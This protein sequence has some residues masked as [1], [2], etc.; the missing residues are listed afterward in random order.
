MAITNTDW[1]ATA[2]PF[3]Y[4]TAHGF[5]SSTSEWTFFRDWLVDSSGFLGAIIDDP[6]IQE[7]YWERDNDKTKTIPVSAI[8]TKSTDPLLLGVN[9]DGMEVGDID[10]SHGGTGYGKFE[11]DDY[12]KEDPKDAFI[13]FKGRTDGTVGG[14]VYSLYAYTAYAWVA[15]DPAQVIFS[16]I[17][18][19]MNTP[20]LATD[21]LDKASFQAA[22]DYYD[23]NPLPLS[24]WREVGLTL[25]QQ[26]KKI[27][28][29]TPDYLAIRPSEADGKIKLHLLPRQVGLVKR[30]TAVD[31][32]GASV[33]SYQVTP[34]DRH[35]L[36]RITATF[37][38][39]FMRF[40][41][42]PNVAADFETKRP[43]DLPGRGR[44]SV[45]QKVGAVGRDRSV[46][47]DLPYSPHS[48]AIVDHVDLTYWAEDQAEVDVTFADW[49][50]LNFDVGDIVVIKSNAAG[51]ATTEFVVTEKR[52]DLDTLLANARFR[53]LVG[54]AGKSPAAVDSGGA[55]VGITPNML[56]DYFEADATYPR[57]LAAAADPRNLDRVRGVVGHVH[58][59]TMTRG[60]PPV[61]PEM[62]VNDLNG[63]STMRFGGAAYS[64]TSGLEFRTDAAAGLAAPSVASGNY[65]AYF[66]VNPNDV[67]AR[68]P[69]Y[70]F[71]DG[72]NRLGF[73]A[74]NFGV[75]SYRDTVG[76]HGTAAALTG[77]QI[78]VF[79][80]N[81]TG[82][83]IRRNGALLESGL[84]YTA[85]AL[86]P[87]GNHSLGVDSD[88]SHSVFFGEI[89]EFRLF[90]S[91]HSTAQMQDIEAHLA[92][93]YDITI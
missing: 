89:A 8:E 61:A 58:G 85:Q 35:T 62:L 57:T 11:P 51:F 25:A 86:T 93:K 19:Y 82:A 37:G 6:D 2:D 78:L 66:V 32:D 90:D 74:S 44:V 22:S 70:D 39:V 79:N 88:G 3:V 43:L 45:V 80:L 34:T 64:V 91:A 49:S 18:H 92:D 54:A 28:D 12:F 4:A 75:L 13:Y 77:W 81:T 30:V 27:V 53:Q 84:P 1:T 46:V 40:Y 73:F 67:V 83:A 24:L 69:L 36:D 7:I 50:H 33:A 63:W 5:A 68:R 17:A 23:T 16:I 38:G 10:H 71:S 42:R 41:F 87:G 60:V 72:T 59:V 21:Y 29:H 14:N 76:W 65:T 56:G 55:I 31:L 26:V 52:V 47:V 15:K 9:Y 48:Q 20:T